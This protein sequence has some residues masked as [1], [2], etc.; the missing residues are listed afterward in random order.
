MDQSLERAGSGAGEKLSRPNRLAVLAFIADPGSEQVLRDGLTEFVADGIDI[1]RGTIKTAIATMTRLQTPEVLIVDISGEVSPLQSLQHLSEVIEPS[2]RVLVIGETDEV[3]FYRNITHGFGVAEYLFKPITR[4]AVA[5]HFVPM[6][7]RK[8]LR[9]DTTLGG[10]VVAIIA[11]RGGAGATTIAGNV[12]WYLGIS[13]KR[14]TVFVDADL[15]LGFG[16]MLLGGK[17]GPGLRMAL[18]SADPVDPVFASAA[19]Q[20]IADRLHILA[21]DEPILKPL[22]YVPGA[23][24][25]MIEAL[26]TRYNFIV[27]DLPFLPVPSHQEL[28]GLAHH[29]VVV[30]DPTLASVRDTLRLLALPRGPWQPQSPTLVL[31]REGRSGG[32]TRKQI[33]E[34]L[35]TKIDI[36]IPDLSK[37]LQESVG[38]GRPMVA[39]RGPFMDA[40]V[41]LSR[42]IGFVGLHDGVVA[43]TKLGGSIGGLFKRRIKARG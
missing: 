35:K 17:T 15:H 25:R 34:A 38:S 37:Q 36:V 22:N 8:T 43:P 19:P 5:R 23:A 30:M 12:A 7:T 13:G 10:R 18:E 41:D 40:I 27:L 21:G 16:A 31:N 29:R 24:R 33:E 14:H 9:E 32:L 3:E 2:V 42:E 11:A 28:L 26:R 4:E 39:H 6:I 20:P 1:R